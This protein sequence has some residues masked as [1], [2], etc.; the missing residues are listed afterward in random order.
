M[1]VANVEQWAAKGW[2]N[3]QG[4]GAELISGETVRKNIG[5]MKLTIDFASTVSIDHW[6]TLLF[7]TDDAASGV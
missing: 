5:N 2:Q 7:D 4:D 6:R 3:G 1:T